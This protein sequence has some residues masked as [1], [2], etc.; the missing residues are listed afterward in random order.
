MR[1]NESENGIYF[2]IELWGNSK[3]SGKHNILEKHFTSIRN[4]YFSPYDD[5]Y[6][7]YSILINS[8]CI[9]SWREERTTVNMGQG[10][11]QERQERNMEGNGRE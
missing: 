4:Q 7:Y 3:S 1:C 6:F 10:E 8:L 9:S 5:F 2:T 11:S